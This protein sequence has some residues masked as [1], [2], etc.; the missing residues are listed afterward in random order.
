MCHKTQGY[1]NLDRLNRGHRAGTG[2]LENFSTGSDSNVSHWVS[3][4]SEAPG[5]GNT[6]LGRKVLDRRR[7]DRCCGRQAQ[8]QPRTDRFGQDNLPGTF[9]RRGD[10]QKSE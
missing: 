4:P 9:Q 8:D 1:A 7:R 10:L 2:S 3:G 6:T 5:L